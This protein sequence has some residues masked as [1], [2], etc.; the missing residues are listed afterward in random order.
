M[1]PVSV[2]RRSDL[3]KPSGAD[4]KII[5]SPGAAAKPGPRPGG[6]GC[7]G[8]LGDGDGVS[9]G[10]ELADVV[11]DP[12]VGVQAADVVGHAEVAVAG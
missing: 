7:S 10:F 3:G 12:A 9:E 8:G 4:R 5:P 1:R 2:A 11:A 6:C